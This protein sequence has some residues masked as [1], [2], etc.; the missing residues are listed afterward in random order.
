V[1]S[2]IDTIIDI[3]RSPKQRVGETMGPAHVVWVKGARQQA[4]DGALQ[5]AEFQNVKLLQEDEKSA[6]CD[7]NCL[8]A[9]WLGRKEFVGWV[10]CACMLMSWWAQRFWLG[11]LQGTG[12][13]R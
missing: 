13:S 12:F 9:R 7:R 6:P 8:V 10:S 5:Q 11:L 2:L 4:D 3:G 1:K